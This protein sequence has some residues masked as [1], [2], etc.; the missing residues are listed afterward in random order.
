MAHALTCP[1]CGAALTVKANQTIVRCT[2]CG[3]TIALPE[4]QAAAPQPDPLVP[5]PTLNQV[6]ALLRQEKRVQATQLYREI[7]GARLNE[8][9][10]AIDHFV[11]SE[12]LRRP[13]LLHRQ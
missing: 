7:T 3:N 11:A 9:K 10:T 1:N 12:P 8:A 6:A 2:F 5:D 13:N 4:T